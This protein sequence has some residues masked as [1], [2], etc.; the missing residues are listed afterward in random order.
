[1]N[2][3]IERI[4]VPAKAGLPKVTKDVVLLFGRGKNCECGDCPVLYGG[5]CPFD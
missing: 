3:R 5:D 1:M 4:T 2:L